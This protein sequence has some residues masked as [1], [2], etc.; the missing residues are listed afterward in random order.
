MT[1][2]CGTMAKWQASLLTK[3]MGISACISECRCMLYLYSSV[4]AL[5][6]LYT[7]ACIVCLSDQFL[8]EIYYGI[9]SI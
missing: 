5:V 7:C 9:G 1:Y 3:V 4:E 6:I 8:P 2:E